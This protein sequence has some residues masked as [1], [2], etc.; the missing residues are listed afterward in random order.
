MRAFSLTVL[1]T[2]VTNF[3]QTLCSLESRVGG[4]RPG[5]VAEARPGTAAKQ[6]EHRPWTA[7]RPTTAAG[8][9]VAAKAAVASAA[10]A[11]ARPTT[12]V[13]SSAGVSAD[14][15]E[16]FAAAKLGYTDAL[17]YA[18]SRGR[19]APSAVDGLGRSLL[20]VAAV[21][22]RHATAEFLLGHPELFDL[23]QIAASGNSILHTVVTLGDARMAELLLR[24]G[25]RV[26]IPSRNTG[27]TP[28]D[29]AAVMD[30]EAILQLF[31]HFAPLVA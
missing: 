18:L 6:L 31:E 27:A 19:V 11:A 26:D 4:T 16:A 29:I 7:A 2:A 17:Y 28:R 13:A 21:H 25:A 9:A 22:Q 5:T 15:D 14:A 23:N 12:A 8:N 30:H 1:V 10:A 20:F 3:Y 24:A